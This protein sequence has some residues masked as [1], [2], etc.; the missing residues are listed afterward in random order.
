MGLT[1]EKALEGFSLAGQNKTAVVVGATQGIGAGIARRLSKLGCTRIITLGRNEKRGN[2]VI[3]AMKKLAP[4]ASKLEA[5]F[6]SGDLQY[7]QSLILK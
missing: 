7:V 4:D 6:V 3:E 5:R 1:A 2:E